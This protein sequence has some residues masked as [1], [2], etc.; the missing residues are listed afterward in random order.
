[1]VLKNIKF[2]DYFPLG[3]SELPKIF[4]LPS[5]SKK[6]HFPY[7]FNTKGNENYIYPLPAKEYHSPNTMKP[8]EENKF[9]E[10]YKEHELD[11]FDM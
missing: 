3:L 8:E 2:I 4:T 9:L 10:W 11:L 1:M 5:S 7:L 6:G